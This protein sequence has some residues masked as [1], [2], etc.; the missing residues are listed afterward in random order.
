MVAGTFTVSPRLT[1]YGRF[2]EIKKDWKALKDV[3]C[4]IPIPSDNDIANPLACHVVIVSGTFTD[5]LFSPVL[6]FKK[7]I[8]M[9]LMFPAAA[10]VESI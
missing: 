4:D 8:K 9:W 5:N 7:S 10:P 3:G 6:L 2:R 1:A